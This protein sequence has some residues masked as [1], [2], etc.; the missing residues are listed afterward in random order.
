MDSPV[1]IGIDVGGTFT[2]LIAQGDGGDLAVRKVPSTPAHPERGVIDVLQSLLETT[3]VSPTDIES[4]FHGSTV[5]TNALLERAGADTGLLLTDGFDAVPIVGTQA[6][7]PSETINPFY[8]GKQ[9]L[10]PP[11]RTMQIPERVEHDGSVL[12]ELDETA[13]REAVSELAAA[14]VESIAVCYLFSF[15]TADHEERTREIIREEHPDWQVSLSA[16][17]AP[18]IR[19]Y[20]RLST[21]AIDAY[22]GP[23]LRTYLQELSGELDDLGVPD[24]RRFFMLSHGGLVP[25]DTAEEN[26]CRTLRSGP[27]AGVMAGQFVGGELGY[28]D[29]VTVDMGGT[30]CDVAVVVDGEIPETTDSTPDGFPLSVPTVEIEAIGAGGGTKASVEDGRL[31]VGPESA[32]ADPGPVCYGRGGDDPTVTDANVVLGRLSRESLLGGEIDVAAERARAAIR[33]RVGEPLGMDAVEAATA[34]LELVTDE[35]R[36][37]IQLSLSR[38]GHDP[39]E[40][41]LFAYGGAGP[42]H[43]PRLASRLGIPKVIVPRQPGVN[44]AFGLLTTDIEGRYAQSNVQPLSA[45]SATAIERQFGSLEREAIDAREREGFDPGEIDV[46]RRLDLRYQGQGYELSIPV[47][48]DVD[49]DALEERFHRTHEARYGHRGDESVEVVTFRVASTVAVEPP[50]VTSPGEDVSP[51]ET[52]VPETTRAVYDPE[53]EAFRDTPIYGRTDL[54]ESTIAGP[55]I[56]EQLDTTIVIEPGQRAQFD[57]HGNAIIE[58]NPDE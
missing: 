6:R 57:A 1:R 26:G 34:I 5:T 32:G 33:D 27:A 28:D 8:G 7:P 30:S 56:V 21:T 12:R 46:E 42:T 55:A 44:S 58:V 24:R 4:I 31:H 49:K 17:V 29:L 40:F 43:A 19:E 25:F 9:F 50:E 41:A 37:E 18:H 51:D 10:V 52:P 13:V 11:R 15:L 35:M 45:L 47:D 14:G 48:G 39:R 3:P 54:A 22:V 2:D 38:R 16:D 36:S 53:S 23:P 20:A